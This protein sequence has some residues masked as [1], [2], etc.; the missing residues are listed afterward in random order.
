VPWA[1]GGRGGLATAPRRPGGRVDREGQADRGH[2]PASCAGSRASGRR[3]N[4]RR[5]EVAVSREGGPSSAAAL[6]ADPFA[7]QAAR[8]LLARGSKRPVKVPPV[9]YLDTSVLVKCYVEE[10]GSGRRSHCCAATGF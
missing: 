6:E 8:R 2:S 10:P 9:G 7:R 1:D 4:D 3:T 5:R